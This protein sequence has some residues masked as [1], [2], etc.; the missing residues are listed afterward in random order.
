MARGN[1]NK[2]EKFLTNTTPAS[3][4]YIPLIGQE[5]ASIEIPPFRPKVI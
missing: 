1:L 4:Y 2:I 5:S 3:K